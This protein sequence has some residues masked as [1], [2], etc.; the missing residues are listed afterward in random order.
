[1]MQKSLLWRWFVSLAAAGS[2]VG[3]GLTLA[4]FAARWWWRC[5]QVCHF[6]VQYFWLLL[7]AA[8][9]LL[10]ATRRRLG[11]VAAGAALLNAAM[12]API[13][14]PVPSV[15]A[16]GRDIRV[17]LFNVLS[18]NKQY[19][20]VLAYLRQQ[21]ADIVLLLEVSPGWA[22]AIQELYDIYPHRH[23][24][25]RDDNFGIALLSRIPWHE[26]QIADFGE[27]AVPSLVAMMS[28]EGRPLV[29]V[30][31]HPLPPGSQRMAALRHGQL[32][33]V[34]K[35]VGSNSSSDSLNVLMGDLNSTEFSPYFRD[36]LWAAKLRDSRQGR[37]IQ[38]S[39][40]ALPLL[41]IPLDHCLVSP[42]IGV[43]GRRVGP[44]LGSDHRPVIVDLRFP[45]MGG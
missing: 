14:W 5:E 31:T 13:Y 11:A 43:L 2:V 6:R 24:V 27:A 17:V 21:Q 16:R 44:H 41:E 35:Y 1:M 10:A 42:S 28:I 18:E 36:L 7:L 12:I 34:G 9:V 39:W 25:A 15:P 22:T 40:Q 37:G 30:G 20:E 45:A 26:V 38:A 8:V 32:A 33:A 3:I 23:V 4:G 19:P 29:F